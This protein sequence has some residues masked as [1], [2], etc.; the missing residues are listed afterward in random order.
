VFIYFSWTQT[1]SKENLSIPSY[2]WLN[3]FR[4]WEQYFVAY[5]ERQDN[6]HL[7]LNRC[8]GVC[9]KLEV[10]LTTRFPSI[11]REAIKV[12]V[13]TRTMLRI[14]S[15]NTQI[16][17]T[18]YRRKNKSSQFVRS[19]QVVPEVSEP[20]NDWDILFDTVINPVECNNAMPEVSEPTTDWD[21]LFDTV[22]NPVEC[23][24]ANDD[25]AV[26]DEELMDII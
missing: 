3:L 23:N 12:Y 24:N 11:P 22:I 5:H 20:T 2:D 25:E 15:L 21:I 9:A 18:R 7:D 8:E 10:L 17:N 13:K 6:D 4:K 14:K 26:E 1:I 16:K 19:A